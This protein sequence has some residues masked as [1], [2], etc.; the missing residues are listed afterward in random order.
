M[1]GLVGVPIDVCLVPDI[2]G[3]SLRGS[4]APFFPGAMT[5]SSA[6]VLR[7]GL[8]PQATEFFS[9]CSGGSYILC[10]AHFY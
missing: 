6:E 9:V 10:A 3:Q 2:R 4:P 1:S 8:T 7:V 5:L